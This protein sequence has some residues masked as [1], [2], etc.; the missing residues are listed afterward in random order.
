MIITKEIIEKIKE[1]Q[2]EAIKEISDLESWSIKADED[3]KEKWQALIDKLSNIKNSDEINILFLKLFS[4]LN[5]GDMI[6]FVM[7]LNKK[8]SEVFYGFIEEIENFKDKEKE[9]LREVFKEKLM[10]LYRLNVIPK[11]FSEDRVSA[12]RIAL[13]KY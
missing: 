12:L 6:K 4:Y 10:V 11:I 9:E 7:Q 5:T 13:G 3:L 2:E 8:D 1:S